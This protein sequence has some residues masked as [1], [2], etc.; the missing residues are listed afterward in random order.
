M[1]QEAAMER[2]QVM[3]KGAM[4]RLNVVYHQSRS[5]FMLYVILFAVLLVLAVFVVSKLHRLGKLFF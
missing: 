3:M 5:N 1:V 4:K 2:A